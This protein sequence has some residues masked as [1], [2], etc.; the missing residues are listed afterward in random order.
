VQ[1]TVKVDFVIILKTWGAGWMFV[2]KHE[3]MGFCSIGAS[4]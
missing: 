3:K 4:V 1:F 2:E